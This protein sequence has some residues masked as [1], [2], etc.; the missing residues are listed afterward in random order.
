VSSLRSRRTGWFW[1]GLGLG[2]VGGYLLTQQLWVLWQLF[3]QDVGRSLRLHRNEARKGQSFSEITE[4]ET[5]TRRHTVDD[6]I[7]RIAYLPKLRRFETPILMQHGMWHGAWCWQLWQEL[8]AQWG[9]ETHTHS[10]P[11]HGRSLLQRP[12]SR[13]TLDYYLG[14][15]RDE[16]DRFPC[17]AVLM[18]HSMGGALTQWYLKYVTDDLPAAVLVAPWVSHSMFKD[19][20][21][22]L[23]TYD[24]IGCLLMT[25]SWDATPLVRMARGSAV[26][27]LIGPRAALPLAELQAR[28]GSESALVLYQHNPPFWHPPQRVSTPMLWIAGEDDPLLVEPAERRSA[29]HYQ[30]DYIVAEKS[31]HNVMM[32]HGYRSTAETIHE[33]LVKQGVD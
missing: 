21:L 5:C 22:R 14:F 18:G 17:R 13:C 30:A 4:T 2:A 16:M 33:W 9:W 10:L 24:P 8:F 23:I 15:L 6:G 32:D 29:A 12:L 11:G 7:E 27:F 25:L 19:G 3:A 31:R 26:R 1:V 28:L 20:L